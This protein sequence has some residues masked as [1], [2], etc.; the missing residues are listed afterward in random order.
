MAS[1]AGGGGGGVGGGERGGPADQ[2]QRLRG[3][4]GGGQP[5][6]GDVRGVGGRG[7]R[8]LLPGRLSWLRPAGAHHGGLQLV[9]GV[10]QQLQGALQRD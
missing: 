7:G 3:L 10:G 9:A 5:Q 8:A 4:S 2:G 6:L 1:D